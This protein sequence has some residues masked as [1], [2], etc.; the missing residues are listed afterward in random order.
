MERGSPTHWMLRNWPNPPLGLGE[1]RNPSFVTGVLGVNESPPARAT[2]QCLLG[3]CTAS[4][5]SGDVAL[6]LQPW[7]FTSKVAFCLRGLPDTLLA[8]TETCALAK[9]EAEVQSRVFRGWL[10]LGGLEGHLP[11]I[12]SGPGGD[13][14]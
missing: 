2:F 12:P 13:Q 5:V 10:F 3:S 1:P 8:E 7:L 14:P 6:G 11:S 9:P 4:P